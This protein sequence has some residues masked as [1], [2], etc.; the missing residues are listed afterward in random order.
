MNIFAAVYN[1]KATSLAYNRSNNYWQ[2]QIACVASGEE[3]IKQFGWREHHKHGVQKSREEEPQG[4]IWYS[5]WTSSLHLSS[6]ADSGMEGFSA[7]HVRYLPSSSIPGT[8]VRMLMVWLPSSA[9]YRKQRTHTC[10]IAIEPLGLFR[11]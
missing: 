9:Y 6:R 4:E 2:P 1:F 8:N 10:V 11:A 3:V 5:Q 7:R